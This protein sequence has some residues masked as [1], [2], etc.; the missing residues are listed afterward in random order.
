[1]LEQRNNNNS[2][3]MKLF[4]EIG[5]RKWYTINLD[6]QKKPTNEKTINVKYV[7]IS[8]S[9]DIDDIFADILK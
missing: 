3:I 6:Y 8:N 2:T 4:Y 1:M 5:T 9:S 7:D